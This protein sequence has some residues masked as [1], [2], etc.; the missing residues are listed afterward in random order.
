MP[1]KHEGRFMNSF[2][3]TTLYL[4]IGC[5]C[6]FFS[7]T[8]SQAS[9]GACAG[10]MASSLTADCTLATPSLDIGTTSDPNPTFGI[11]MNSKG[12]AKSTISLIP[13]PWQHFQ[14]DFS[15]RISL[16]DPR[17]QCCIRDGLACS[18]GN[19]I[20]GSWGTDGRQR[21]WRTRRLFYQWRSRCTQRCTEYAERHFYRVFA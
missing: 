2:K 12:S 5:L 10:R 8:P 21:Q 7:S 15:L 16:R 6:L 9:V 1:A 19:V 20:Q 17:R 14:H 4:A 18:S 3:R 11:A 13:C